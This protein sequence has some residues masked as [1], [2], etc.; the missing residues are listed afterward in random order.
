MNLPLLIYTLSQ[1][2]GLDYQN[3]VR[4][5]TCLTRVKGSEEDV[6]RTNI[7]HLQTFPIEYTN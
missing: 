4:F 7:I 1:H 3:R 6:R 2:F 5:R